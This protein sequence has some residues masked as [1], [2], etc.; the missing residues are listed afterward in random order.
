MSITIAELQVELDLDQ[1]KFETKIG[2]AERRTEDFGA[3]EFGTPK[4]DL[5]TSAFLAKLAAA[6]SA[7]AA[8]QRETKAAGRPVPGPVGSARPV[9]SSPSARPVAP[10]AGPGAAPSRSASGPASSASSVEQ[11]Q[12][13]LG[14][15][16]EAALLKAEAQQRV[17]A[18]KIAEIRTAAAAQ[19]A[20]RVVSLEAEAVAQVEAL[21]VDGQ[22][23]AAARAAQV[24]MGELARAA[25]TASQIVNIRTEAEQNAAKVAERIQ[26]AFAERQVQVAQAAAARVVA[27]QNAAPSPAPAR[28]RDASDF[29]LS[30]PA[31]DDAPAPSKDSDAK[32]EAKDDADPKDADAS[33]SSSSSSAPKSKLGALGERLKERSETI[34]K[35]GEDFDKLAE[36][37]QDAAADV[38]KAGMEWGEQIES[39]RRHVKGT[40]E[41]LAGLD[42]G[43]RD[44][45]SGPNAVPIDNEK[46]AGLART[47]GSLGVDAGQIAQYTRTA[48]MLD[49][50]TDLT[51][52]QAAVG[53]AKL[54]AATNLPRGQ[55]DRLGS[56]VVELATK[57]QASGSD[58]LGLSLR[59]ADAG[60]EAGM[61]QAGITAFAASLASAGVQAETG[62]TAM[63]GVFSTMNQAVATGGKSLKIFADTSGLT[64]AQF[65]KDWKENSAG[66]VAAFLEG[67]NQMKSANAGAYQSVVSQFKAPGSG[68][69]VGQLASSA[70]TGGQADIARNLQ[71][72]NAAW[73]QNTA[74]TTQAADAFN[75]TADKTQV[76]NN[77]LNE[78]KI[79]LSSALMPM[80]NQ[81]LD[82]A[83]SE[84]MPMLSNLAHGF[85]GLPKPVQEVVV[86]FGA[87][88]AVAPKVAKVVSTVLDFAG[89]AAEALG[90][91]GDFAGTAAAALGELGDAAVIAFV[92]ANPEVLLAALPLLILGGAKL[93]KTWTGLGQSSTGLKQG[94]DALAASF[95]QLAT[96]TPPGKLADEIKRAGDEAV[97]AGMDVNKL[98][99]AAID[100]A[101]AKR[102][103]EFTVKQPDILAAFNAAIGQTEGYLANQ[104]LYVKTQTVNVGGKPISPSFRGNGTTWTGIRVNH[105]P[106]SDAP[107]PSPDAPAPF[108][109]SGAGRGPQILADARRQYRIDEAAKAARRLA[110]AAAAA[111]K[112]TIHKGVVELAASPGS[113]GPTAV[114]AHG[115]PNIAA[116]LGE[117]GGERGGYGGGYHGGAPV[118][119]GS[120]PLARPQADADSKRAAAL[121]R[122]TQAWSEMNSQVSSLVGRIHAFDEGINASGRH[123]SDLQDTF[124]GLPD[125]VTRAHKALSADTDTLD[126][127][128][129]QK[130]QITGNNNQALY[131]LLVSGADPTGF[132]NAVH[133][134]EKVFN[135]GSRMAGARA[136]AAVQAGIIATAGGST[137]K[138][139]GTAGAS[140]PGRAKEIT[141][142]V[143]AVHQ[144]LPKFEQT[145]AWAVSQVYKRMGVELKTQN[146]NQAANVVAYAQAHWRQVPADEAPAGALLAEP[147]ASANSGWHV[148]I[149][150]GG[151]HRAGSNDRQPQF[152]SV[153]RDAIAFVPTE[154]DGDT[155]AG[156]PKKS[157]GKPQSGAEISA[158]A[159][160]D[161]TVSQQK[162]I[163]NFPQFQALWGPMVTDRAATGEVRTARLAEQKAVFDDETGSD[164]SKRLTP[165]Q[166]EKLRAVANQQDLAAERQNGVNEAAD[167]N[168][169]FNASETDKIGL[170]KLT[171][172][173]LQDSGGSVATYQRQLNLAQKQNEI[174]SSEWYKTLKLTDPTGAGQQMNG[175]LAQD[176]SDFRQEQNNNYGAGQLA[177]QQKFT[178]DD[179]L[180]TKQADFARQNASR[181]PKQLAEGLEK[182]TVWQKAYNEAI[183]AYQSVGEAQTAGDTAVAQQQLLDT[184][185]AGID[186]SKALAAATLTQTDA[187]AALSDQLQASTIANKGAQERQLAVLAARRAA[188]QMTRDAVQGGAITAGQANTYADAAGANAGFN[189][190]AEATIRRQNSDNTAESESD[191]RSAGLNA[192]IG[193]VDSAG[194]VSVRG[195]KDL[196]SKRKLDQMRS[197][198]T[199]ANAQ[200]AP[201]AQLA[202]TEIQARVDAYAAELQK[203]DELAKKEQ[204][205]QNALGA[206]NSALDMQKQRAL[207][208]AETEEDRLKIE[209][210]FQDAAERA[211]GVAVSPQEQAA[212]KQQLEIAHGDDQM[213]AAKATA[214][215]FRD[216]LAQSGEEG[217]RRFGANFIKSLRAALEKS[218]M[219]SVSTTITNGIFGKGAVSDQG[220]LLDGLLAMTGARKARS[221]GAQA[222]ANPDSTSR[223]AAAPAPLPDALPSFAQGLKN[224]FGSGTSLGTGF[225]GRPAGAL[226]LDAGTGPVT[227]PPD[228]SAS[229]PMPAPANTLE[230]ALNT[231]RGG[232]TQVP[233]F[234]AGGVLLGSVQSA[235][236]LP[237]PK[238]DSGDTK[239]GN[240]KITIGTATVEIMHAEAHG[241]SGGTAPAAGGAHG[242]AG[243]GASLE[244]TGLSILGL[245]L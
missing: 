113:A 85:V 149:S 65:A 181:D 137:A 3:R 152:G 235:L 165:A 237:A 227:A 202:P 180:L 55:F 194:P 32:K 47:G 14:A 122:E 70:G 72:A 50:T 38:L 153:G 156:A 129:S 42:Q 140:S 79:T 141:A 203:A 66:T 77:K 94:S 123:A 136:D 101:A 213:A 48:A 10:Q 29:S 9:Q 174:Q 168:D 226:T 33:A 105:A 195:E 23:R 100:L 17:S 176:A 240:A 199:A 25:E 178:R 164:L 45:T 49:A 229:P 159:L 11:M 128:K 177:D 196:E 43:L 58:I 166:A 220:G 103:V 18:A 26:S 98:K 204:S 239:L 233:D 155:G 13:K 5:D 115:A 184:K 154:L 111:Q 60:R 190:D 97:N 6:R 234:S 218:A 71:A 4:V 241:S 147:S 193:D 222:A 73:S 61:S 54:A 224:P 34:A 173:A 135:F 44:V 41:Q 183:D 27:V 217:G 89:T 30:A 243:S 212:R 76:F 169:R 83:N 2:N 125:K 238:G 16:V 200:L 84:I 121:E 143:L 192:Q 208:L 151:R 170:L 144:A 150:V 28:T 59:L 138:G 214:D 96:V 242:K 119:T 223:T 92:V 182:L 244:Q 209:Q 120:G 127:L 40:P 157:Q 68:E 219:Q 145:C 36:P 197:G 81:L 132:L 216:I 171:A 8:F 95:A 186:V 221:Q 63:S 160:A 126:T 162:L 146:N 78:V 102:E 93:Y 56:T 88:V 118:E 35:A 215:Q 133:G 117:T 158:Q 179:Q 86:G 232:A 161:M 210:R 134:E 187:E 67:L 99:K 109:F 82:V 163:G 191:G 236:R 31:D 64:S 225:F 53:M 188:L 110:A 1:T 107:E 37:I 108:I 142:D 80:V 167:A 104:T 106:P 19:A 198:L 57:T 52:S 175:M 51:A 207:S 131:Q 21:Q 15:A 62:G 20:T 112:I 22:T 230:S 205:R 228:P 91:L 148:G 90:G 114:P 130:D 24:Q 75:N 7:F 124:Q 39:V 116:I 46:A 172:K 201:S 87:V 189:Y 74:L 206:V 139:A 185:Q 69:A 231:P 211:S 12:R 245:F